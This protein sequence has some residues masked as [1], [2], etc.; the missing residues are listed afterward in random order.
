MYNLNGQLVATIYEGFM[1]QGANKLTW[2]SNNNPS[3]I[4][5]VNVDGINN[6]IASYKIS[7]LK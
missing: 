3:G 6:S 4:Y 1:S 7:L 2:N 5:F